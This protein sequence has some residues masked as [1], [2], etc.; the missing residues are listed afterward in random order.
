MT[1]YIAKL[2][3]ANYEFA[4]YGANSK[5]A[6]TALKNAFTTHIKKTGGS[7]TW[8]EVRN[9][10]YLDSVRLGEATVR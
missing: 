8:A 9:D 4:G 10:S 6:L 5:E 1:I 3:T 7:L 2:E